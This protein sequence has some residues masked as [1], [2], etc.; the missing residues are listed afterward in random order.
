MSYLR[1]FIEPF[2]ETTHGVVVMRDLLLKYRAYI[3][4]LARTE[5]AIWRGEP[6]GVCCP[7]CDAPIQIEGHSFTHEGDCPV[8]EAR[9]LLGLPVD[10]RGNLVEEES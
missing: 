4:R 2:S 10:E 3:E 5:L 1:E 9:Q 6:A 8:V 7:H